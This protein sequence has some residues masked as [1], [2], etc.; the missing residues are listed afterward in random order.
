MTPEQY[1]KATA[2]E[3]KAFAANTY[4]LKLPLTMSP[5]TMR[6]K[7]DDHCQKNGLEQMVAEVT[8]RHERAAG[9][10]NRIKILIPKQDKKVKSDGEEP[11]H[12]GVQ[13]VAYLIPRGIPVNVSPAIEEV[14]RHAVQDNVTQ[15]EDGQIMHNE[16]ITYPYQILAGHEFLNPEHGQAA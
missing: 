6:Q 3:L 11:V 14:L 9:N 13:G 4:D 1:A 8:T 2:A 10:K 12:L 5:E 16:S 15:D 7:I